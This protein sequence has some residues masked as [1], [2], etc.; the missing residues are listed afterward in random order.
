MAGEEALLLDLSAPAAAVK[1][2][3][4]VEEAVLVTSGL[5]IARSQAT[6]A[7]WK[8]RLAEIFADQDEAYVAKVRRRP[9]TG[10]GIL[11][12]APMLKEQV[13]TKRIL[14]RGSGGK[15]HQVSI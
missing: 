12:E 15:K 14:A 1:V 10:G 13:E 3:A 2:Q 4:L 7:Q 5:M 9:S 11:A 6:A 8:Q